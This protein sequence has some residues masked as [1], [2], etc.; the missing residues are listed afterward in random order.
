[1]YIKKEHYS[2]SQYITPYLKKNVYAIFNI[3]DLKPF[4]KRWYD[5]FKLGVIKHCKK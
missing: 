5:F 2:L 4:F 1:M 3:K